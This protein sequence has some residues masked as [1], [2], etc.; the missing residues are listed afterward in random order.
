MRQNRRAGFDLDDSFPL[1]RRKLA[2]RVDL[3]AERQTVELV[4]PAVLAERRH[5]ARLLS[6]INPGIDVSPDVRIGN[7]GLS[8]VVQK[9]GEVD[10][11]PDCGFALKDVRSDRSVRN[12]SAQV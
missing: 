5:E 2:E 4:E 10:C 7:E 3:H 8:L 6:E 11:A 1:V 12:Q 9:T